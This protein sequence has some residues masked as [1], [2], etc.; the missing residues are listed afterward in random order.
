MSRNLDRRVEYTLPIENPTV[1]AQVLDQV[2][3][4][5]LIDN[6]QSWVLALIRRQLHPRQAGQA[7]FNLHRYFMTNPSLSGR[8]A[9][10]ARQRGAQAAID[11]T[12]LIRCQRPASNASVRSDHR[13]RL[14]LGPLGAYGGA[15]AR[16][17]TLF[18]EKVMAALGRGVARDGRLDPERSSRRSKRSRVSAHWR[19]EA[20]AAPYRRH[21]RGARRQQRH[22]VPQ[23]VRPRAQ[24]AAAARG[25]EEAAVGL[26]VIPPFRKP[27]MVADLGGGGLEL[28]RIAR[29]RGREGHF[30]PLGVL[31][32]GA[33][34][35]A[36]E[37]PAIK[38]GSRGGA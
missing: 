24:A 12:G 11:P 2:M 7:P 37:S 14:Q 30:L 9:A 31:R 33:E 32:I 21:R 25:E 26:G 38:A 5:N 6:E 15:R 35:D 13:H 17:S 28:V 1:H 36:G 16:L 3:I 22:G 19:D 34:P 8:G 23:A 4:A 10:L 18:N 27:R 29:R 20:Q